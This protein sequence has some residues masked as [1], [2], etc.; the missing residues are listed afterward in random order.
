MTLALQVLFDSL[1]LGGLLAVG[2]LGFSLVWGVL[3]VLNLAYASLIMLGGYVSY[4]LW[5]LGVDYLLTIPLTMVALFAVG[6]LMQRYIIDNVVNGPPTLTIALTYTRNRRRISW[7]R[8]VRQ[9]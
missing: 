7:R 9:I 3:N 6:W 4:G 2:A 5:T 8:V 1:L